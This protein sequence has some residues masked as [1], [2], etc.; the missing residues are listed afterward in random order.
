MALVSS[1]GSLYE[2]IRLPNLVFDTWGENMHIISKELF[3]TLCT[4]TYNLS[5]LCLR[6]KL[7]ALQWFRHIILSSPYS[8]L[9]TEYIFSKAEIILSR[10]LILFNNPACWQMFKRE[11]NLQL[12]WECSAC[13]LQVY[14]FCHGKEWLLVCRRTNQILM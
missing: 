6:R 4:N 10:K 12:F 8:V 13:Y 2:D 11:K 1:H 7:K 3:L 14:L 9:L 5:L